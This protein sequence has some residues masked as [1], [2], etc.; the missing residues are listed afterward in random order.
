MKKLEFYKEANSFLVTL[1]IISFL[2]AFLMIIG[3]VVYIIVGLIFEIEVSFD[4][5]FEYIAVLAVLMFFGV[6]S[7]NEIK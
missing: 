2:T 5:S 7:I 1:S 6:N 4:C 3:G